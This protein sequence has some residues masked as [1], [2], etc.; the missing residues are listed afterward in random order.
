M[1]SAE[2]LC[3]A[4]G[5]CCDGTLFDNVR[6]GTGE[7]AKKLKALG[8][9]V[10]VTRGRAAVTYFRQPCTALCSNRAC[11]VYTGRPRQCREFECGVYKD[12]QAGRLKEVSALNL[13]KKAR[14]KADHIR[15]LL[16]EL[17]DTDESRSLGDRFR[18]TQRRME[19]GGGD[20][21]AE[22]MFAELGLAVHQFNLLAHEKF[23]TK[24]VTVN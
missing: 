23:Y 8:L 10:A 11:R 4:C 13:V 15:Q 1:N 22:A 20:V 19:A 18:R 2:K 7:D 9:P 5:L 6:L 3:L 14:R 21:A 17:G 16:R 24:V 12:A